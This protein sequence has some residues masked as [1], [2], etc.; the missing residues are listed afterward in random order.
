[1]GGSLAFGSLGVT[2]LIASTTA[3]AD[4]IQDLAD[5]L[6]VSTGFALQFSDALQKA[7]SSGDAATKVISKLYENIDKAKEGNQ[8]T[9]DQFRALGIS[10]KEIKSLQPEEAIKRIVSELSKIE[11]V[12]KRVS[13]MRKLLGK[14]GLGLDIKEVDAILQGGIGKW[15]EYGK[16]IKEVSK[17]K[18][19]LTA[20][21]NNLMIAFANL[22]KRFAIDGTVS[23]E[24]FTGAL[25][26]MAAYFVATRIITFTAAMTGFVVALRS[27]TAAG[28]AF[29]IMANGSPL[30][31]A[32]KL[33]AMGTA[34][35]IYH[36]QSS[37]KPESVTYND[38]EVGDPF[39]MPTAADLAKKADEYK[40][41]KRRMQT[42]TR[43]LRLQ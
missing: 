40:K 39:A 14:S 31:L 10:F 19:Q 27:A 13:E 15:E 2:A 36:K 7:G 34:F 4:K 24:K 26:G 38:K 42:K 22:T 16:G 30:I 43:N 3:F 18:D 9:V 21:M 23:V 25:S 35:V 32:L 1:M 29:N 17:L 41:R 20:S 6:G 11:D 8:E 28:V 33:A 12:T 37:E 5:G